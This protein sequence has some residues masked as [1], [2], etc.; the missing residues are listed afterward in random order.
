MYRTMSLGL[1]AGLLLGARH[2]TPSVV[3][4]QQADAIRISLPAARQF[5]VR[6]VTIGRDDLA[7]IRKEV[8][9]SPQ[10]PDLKFYL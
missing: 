10:D 2:P 1:V 9:F 3:L 5:F 7:N 4:V 8:D 6:N